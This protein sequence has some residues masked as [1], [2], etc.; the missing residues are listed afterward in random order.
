MNNLAKLLT[1]LAVLAFVMAVVTNFTGALLNTPAEGYS[2]ACTNLA[3]LA[4]ALVVSSGDR[5]VG[6]GK[7]L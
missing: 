1:A 3:L 6:S 4:I 2:R 5:G 7:P